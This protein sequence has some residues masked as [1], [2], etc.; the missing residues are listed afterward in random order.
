MLG[1]V[2]TTDSTLIA[3]VPC[4]GQ[5]LLDKMAGK[6]KGQKKDEKEK[7]KQRKPR[8]KKLPPTLFDKNVMIARFGQKAVNV[9]PQK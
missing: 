4:I 2:R 3:V 7:E 8:K 5:N 1:T 9:L 6:Q